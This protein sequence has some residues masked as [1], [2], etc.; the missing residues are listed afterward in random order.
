VNLI[1][2]RV[3]KAYAST[4]QEYRNYTPE[5]GEVRENIVVPGYDAEVTGYGA[6]EKGGDASW[7]I[8]VENRDDPIQNIQ[9][10]A[11]EAG[12]RQA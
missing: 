4:T 10:G 3:I 2:E 6:N 12:Y 5:I 9:N 8:S 11:S 1:F 7:F